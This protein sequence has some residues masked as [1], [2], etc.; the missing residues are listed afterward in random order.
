M[1]FTITG[2]LPCFVA[3]VKQFFSNCQNL[4]LDVW[5]T[6]SVYVLNI[7]GRRKKKRSRRA[8]SGYYNR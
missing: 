6:N 2:N 3:V 1:G 8:L 5:L 4:D 7:W